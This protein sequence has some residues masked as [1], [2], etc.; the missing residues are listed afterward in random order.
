MSRVLIHCLKVFIM[1]DDQ[2]NEDAADH[3][4]DEAKMMAKMTNSTPTL[5]R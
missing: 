4:D 1:D 2:D 3:D 5:D